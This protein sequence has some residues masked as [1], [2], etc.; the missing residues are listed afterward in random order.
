MKGA[1]KLQRKIK[2]GSYWQPCVYRINNQRIIGIYR[3]VYL[4][5]KVDPLIEL[6]SQEFGFSFHRPVKFFR[7]V[8]IQKSYKGNQC[9][10]KYLLWETC[11][12]LES[13]PLHIYIQVPY[14]FTDRSIYGF[15]LMEEKDHQRIS[16][17]STQIGSTKYI[18]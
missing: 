11:L 18:Q 1:E 3:A 14:I 7:E 16:E 2:R 12:L 15:I 10:V 6:Y 4:E 13:R 8:F 5:G 17:L 9:W